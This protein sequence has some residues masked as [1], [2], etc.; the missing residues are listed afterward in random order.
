MSNSFVSADTAVA[1]FLVPI[2]IAKHSFMVSHYTRIA[3]KL[4]SR[5]LLRRFERE[6]WIKSVY[7]RRLLRERTKEKSWDVY[8]MEICFE[9]FMQGLELGLGIDELWT[10]VRDEYDERIHEGYEDDD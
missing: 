3:V 9:Y 5:Y 6:A 7:M 4:E 1:S 8:D 2:A 10:F